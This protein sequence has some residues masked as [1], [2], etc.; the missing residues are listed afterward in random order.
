MPPLIKRFIFPCQDKD[1]GAKANT[2]RKVAIPRARE[3]EGSV[4]EG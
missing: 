3:R 2:N 1:W 4:R